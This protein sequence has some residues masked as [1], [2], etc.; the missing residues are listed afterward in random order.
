MAEFTFG[1][2]K[3]LKEPCSP[4]REA[5]FFGAELNEP[6]ADN[7]NCIP[8]IVEP[9]TSFNL[10]TISEGKEV[11]VAFLGVGRTV[12]G[13]YHIRFRW[14]R[15]RDDAL[16][17]DYTFDH[18]VPAGYR[19]YGY[20]YI[21]YVSWEIIENGGYTV[22][23]E[24][25]GA[26]SYKKRIP[27]TVSGI[28][29]EEPEPIPTDGFIP[30]IIAYVL[31]IA[32]F[33][34]SLKYEVEDWV[35][36]F[37]HFAPVFLYI[38]DA[39]ARLAYQ[40]ERFNDWVD[41]ATDKVADILNLTEIRQ[42][43]KTWLDY[44][45]WAWNWIRDAWNN[46]RA[47]VNDWWGTVIPVVYGWIDEAKQ[48]ASLQID[49]LER[50]VNSIL[51]DVNELLAQIPDVSELTAWF[52][53][54]WGNILANLGSWWDDR[55]LDVQGLIDSA[56]GLREPFWA[57]WQDIRDKVFEFFDDPLEWLLVRFTDWFLGPEV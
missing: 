12:A 55:L 44:A 53:N 4:Y 47:I 7:W 52:S 51:A 2:G 30:A 40:F 32:S 34:L 31:S 39:F 56:F 14:Y 37:Y 35:W 48:W 54:W 24:V 57:G 36:P 41:F 27:F 15:D 23:I 19:L 25:T 1:I 21:G 10:S 28:P 26:E 22:E 18:T 42:S 46:V 43:L 5:Y 8:R 17:Y 29:V 11:A 16:L 3:G 6:N 45:T 13:A 20:S 38:A 49:S 9:T 33:F 50:L